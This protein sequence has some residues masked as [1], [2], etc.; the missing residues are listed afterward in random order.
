MRA[1]IVSE[2]APPGRR[3]TSGAARRGASAATRGVARVLDFLL[4]A[5]CAGCGGAVDESAWPG[6][7]CGSCRLA[8]PFVPAPVCDRCGA[9][10]GAGRAPACLECAD[11]PS[12]LQGAR[13][14]CLLAS[15]ARELVHALKYQGWR[16][17]GAFMGAEMARRAPRAVRE[18]DCLVPVPTSSRNERRRG[19]N[20]ARVIAEAMADA[21][22]KPLAECLE[23]RRQKGTQT[24][25]NPAQRRANVSH[26]FALAPGRE[27]QVADRRVV[28]VDD[29]LTTG[30]TLLAAFAAMAPA[31]PAGV[32]ACAFARAAPMSAP[33]SAALPSLPEL[34]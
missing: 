23:R 9:P 13:A 2:R 31:A 32:F 18:A 8:L 26:A 27:A 20:Q 24:S 28:L 1:G 17:A 34:R 21:L 25:L 3:S 22:N 4:P 29:V 7:V 5:A 11:W 16:G 6:P 12:A 14:V 30:A 19:Y 33:D 10:M 15:P